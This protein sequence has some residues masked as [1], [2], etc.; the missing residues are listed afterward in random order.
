MNQNAAFPR[1][2]AIGLAL[3]VTGL[4]I[5]LAAGLY[6]F[7][8]RGQTIPVV[9]DQEGSVTATETGAGQSGSSMLRINLSAGEAAPDVV[10][11]SIVVGGDPL[12]AVEVQ[13]ILDRLPELIAETDDELDF[14]LREST[15]PAPRPGETVV[16]S[17]P[18]PPTDVTPP[19]VPSGPLE[20]LRF[21]PE[22][23]IPAA[24]FVSVTFNQPMVALT[25]LEQLAE[26]AVPVSITPPLPGTWNWLGVQTLTFDYTGESDRLPMATEYRVEIPAGTTSLSGGTLAETV[27]WTF[28]TPPP[29]VQ[30]LTPTGDSQPLEPIF[31]IRFDQSVAPTAVL[32]ATRLTANGR[33]YPLRLATAAEIEADEAVARLAEQGRAERQFAFRAEGVLPQD[34]PFTLEIGPGTPSAEGPLTTESAQTYNFRTYAPLRIDEHR[35]GWGWDECHPLN[36][37]HIIFNNAL[38]AQ[39]FAAEMVVIE[40]ELPGAAV[41]VNGNTLTIQGMSKG[42][43]TYRVTVNGSLPDVFGQTLGSTQSVTFRVGPAPSVLTGPDRPFVTLDPLRPNLSVYSINYNRLNVRVYAVE[44]SDW[45]A[46]QSYQQERYRQNPPPIP[47]RELANRSINISGEADG[48]TETTLELNEF[49]NNGFGHLIIAIEPPASL[50]SNRSWRQEVIVWVQATQIGLDAF[51]DPGQLLAWTTN[52]ADGS[53]LSGVAVE[54]LPGGESGQSGANGLATI[55]LTSS[56]GDILVARQ[57]DDVAMLPSSVYAWDGGGWQRQTLSDELRWFVYDDRAMY[58]PGEEVHVKGWLRRLEAGTRGDVA[59]VG[60]SSTVR[61]TIYDSRYNEIGGGTANVS[62]L[63]GFDL[64]FT[65]PDNMNLGY[66]TVELRAQ[67]AAGSV[68]NNTYQHNFQAQEFRRPEFEVSARNESTGP[69][70]V[71]GQATLAVAANY[72]AGGPLPN[73]ETTWRVSSTP[74]S[75]SPPN[76]PEFTFGYWTP[77]W[78]IYDYSYE[79]GYIE[80]EP[81]NW[82]TFTGLT[83]AGGEHFL[84]LDFESLGGEPRPFSVRAEATVMDVNRQAWTAGT[85]L[86]VHP[87]NLYVGLRSDRSFV[88]RGTPLEIEAIVA[89][90]DGNAISGRTIEMRAARLEWKFLNGRWDEIEAAV[91]ECTVTSGAEPVSCTFTTEQGGTYQ[92][93]ATV[94]DDLGR[95]NKSQFTRW[96]SGGQRPPARNV[97]QETVTLIPDKESYQPG[98]VAEILVQAPFSPAEGLLLVSRSGLLYS[99]SFQLSGDGITLRVPIED[100]HIPNLNIQ[101]ELVGAAPRLSDDGEPLS[102]V[103]PRPAYATGSLNLSVPPLNRVLN[104]DAALGQTALSPGESTTLDVT[105][106]DANGRAVPNAEFAVVVVDEAVLALTGYQLADPLAIFYPQRPSLVGSHY[107]RANIILV[108]PLTLADQVQGVVFEAVVERAAMATAGADMAMDDGAMPPPMAAPMEMAEGEAAPDDPGSPIQIRR[109]FNPLATFAPETRTDAAGRA[110]LTIQ[111]PDNLTRYRVMVVA[112]SDGRYFGTSEANLTARLPLMVRPSAPRFLNFGDQIELPVVVQ[113]QTDE[114]M[115]VEIALQTSNL[116]LTGAAGVRVTVPAQDRVE[117]RFPATTMRP[118]TARFQVAAVSGPYA[119]AAEGELPVYTPA[120]TE[121]FATYGVIDSGAIAQPVQIPNNVFPQFGGLEITTSSTAVQALTDAVIYLVDYPFECS[122][123]LAS[124]ILAVA[125]LRDVLTAFAAEGLPEAAVLQAGVQRDIERL[126]GL[127]NSDG[128]YP[129]WRYGD[130]SWPYYS[131]YAAHALHVAQEKGFA[132]SATNQEQSLRHLRNIEDYY[133]PWYGEQARISL[134]AYALHVRHLMDDADPGKARNLVN[135]HGLD[136]I[137]LEAIGWL[138]PV[139]A[140]D[141]LANDIERHLNNRA[142]ETAGA[143]NFFTSYSDDAY[144]MLHSNRRTDGIILDSLIRMRP[145]SDLIPKVVNG[146]LAHRVNGRWGNTQENTFILLAL[147]RYFNTFES[148]TPDFVARIWLGDG[149]AGDYAF[150]GR[151]TERSQT[152]IPMSFLFESEGET[153]DLILSKE[154]DGR[155]YYRLGLR[156]APTDLQLPPLDRGFVVQRRY[157]AVDDPEDVTQDENGVWHIRAGARV[158]VQLTMV[159][160]SRRYHVALVDYLP[161]GLEI[162]N[163]DLAVSESL[164][165]DENESVGGG[166]RGYFTW[167]WWGRWYQHQNLRDERAEAF[168]TLLWDGVYTYSYVARATTPGEF[169]APPAKAEEMYAPEVFGRSASDRV[170]VR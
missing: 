138:W 117:V 98:D 114:P 84:Q 86:L 127:Q 3:I 164:P 24:P 116:A 47:G 110:Q 18:P 82:E 19:D 74:G 9:I 68:N 157:E 124:R 123:Q 53:P 49:L 100:A 70:F 8:N 132:V 156:Y 33:A 63:G 136:N 79:Y 145:Q 168:T 106:T 162:I 60:G 51:A 105:V 55:N 143:A 87:A 71:G 133:P 144:L 41:S 13:R 122:E 166:G 160:T 146:L 91:Q 150:R 62:P 118:G 73:A 167:W 151:T 45:P 111:L 26:A 29:Q 109:D 36:P 4:I 170:I 139:L 112:V 147:D 141:P 25:T 101:V 22:G 58:R 61:Y 43:T 130:E 131:I 169:V 44:P 115:T 108:N 12:T 2:L 149:Y 158:R 153:Q 34:T 80:R 107:S 6:F 142:V 65:L 113:N 10:A 161:A 94:V 67:G 89:D 129:I 15:L 128:G 102:N 148:V 1:R 28:R 96:V 75:Y 83:D 99:E 154:G 46:Y 78:R 66:A 21:A 11:P 42:R 104:V 134:S 16:Q 126:E 159:A 163:P 7:Q 93:S 103:P 59:L 85:N 40:P 64:A 23:E 155:L 5:A 120:T 140:N 30:L 152:N 165:R 38:D 88:T 95:P 50:L 48:L 39:N 27:S 119:D 32:N 37:F 125:S 76:W 97:E 69:Y 17:F 72:F 135:Q 35:C 31:F 137:S 92:I 81:E 14:N 56:K 121:A 57:G 20:V 54:L 77:W 90:L 52:L